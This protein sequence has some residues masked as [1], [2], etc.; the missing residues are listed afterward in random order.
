MGQ[1]ALAIPKGT[2]DQQKVIA[3]AFCYKADGIAY[4]KKIEADLARIFPEVLNAEKAYPGEKNFGE[5]YN[6]MIV[7]VTETFN[8]ARLHGQYP[9][10]IHLERAGNSLICIV[11]QNG[12]FETPAE[13]SMNYKA[14]ENGRGLALTYI[15]CGGK[16]K[17][18]GKAGKVTIEYVFG[19]DKER[20]RLD[21]LSKQGSFLHVK[22]LADP[23]FTYQMMD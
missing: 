23:P 21:A 18:D 5:H 2:M 15:A 9:V 1:Q 20:D 13:I 16:M 8:N 19:E 14:S 17:P 22:P 4:V 11:E 12:Q 6:N 10:N 3:N 7:A